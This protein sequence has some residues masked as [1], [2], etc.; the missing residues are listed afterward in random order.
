M[1]SL[2]KVD[3]TF[4]HIATWKQITP[5][6]W[7]LKAVLGSTIDIKIIQQAEKGCFSEIK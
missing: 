7:I 3:V 2:N 4:H 6:Q 1:K 5:D